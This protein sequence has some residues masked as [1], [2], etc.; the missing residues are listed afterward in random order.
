MVLFSFF[1]YFGFF[2][3]CEWVLGFWCLDNK[4]VALLG[5]SGVLEFLG[6][7]GLKWVFLVGL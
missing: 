3:Y 4:V 1:I 7:L 2:S 6:Q 5:L